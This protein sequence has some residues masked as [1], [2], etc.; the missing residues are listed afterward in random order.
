MSDIQRSQ[1]LVLS[2]SPEELEVIQRAAGADG[3]AAADVAN[4][5]RQ[6]IVKRAILRMENA[7]LR[8]PLEDNTAAAEPKR[9]LGL[10]RCRCGYTSDPAGECDGSCVMHF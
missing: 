2:V 8:A 9:S 1:E 3:F 6:L 10:G 5:A 7:D 4:W